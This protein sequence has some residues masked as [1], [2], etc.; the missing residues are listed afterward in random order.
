MNEC[1]MFDEVIHLNSINLE[2]N[3]HFVHRY[4]FSSTFTNKIVIIHNET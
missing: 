3:L 1:V 4:S 2:N